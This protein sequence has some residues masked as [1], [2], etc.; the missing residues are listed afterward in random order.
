MRRFNQLRSVMG[1]AA[2]PVQEAI[3][4]TVQ[5][6]ADRLGISR[7]VAYRQV[8]RGRDGDG[9]WPAGTWVCVTPGQERQLI[10]IN[11]LRLQ[12]HLERAS[13]PEVY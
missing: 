1:K 8:E 7:S 10:R 12:E 4:L 3:Y 5:E 2:E 13:Q 9:G 6:A 11:W